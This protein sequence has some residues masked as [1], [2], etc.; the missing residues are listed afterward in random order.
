MNGPQYLRYRQPPMIQP[1][2]SP[3]QRREAQPRPSSASR[4][5]SAFG[6]ALL[7]VTILAFVF[8]CMLVIGSFE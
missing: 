8:F 7:V 6:I 2:L 1:R 5:A 4:W 3:R